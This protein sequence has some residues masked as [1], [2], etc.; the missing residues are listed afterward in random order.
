MKNTVFATVALAAVAL[1]STAPA[2]AWDPA[3]SSRDSYVERL[4]ERP[5]AGS[6]VSTND[7]ARFATG[8]AAWDP[9]E[10]SRDRDVRLQAEK[11][12]AFQGQSY[13]PTRD[14]FLTD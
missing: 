12:P 14:G 4:A 9:A 3:N 7:S 11:V 1:T 13:I 2:F 5:V 10:T 6:A 8:T